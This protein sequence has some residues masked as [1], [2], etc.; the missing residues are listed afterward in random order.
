MEFREWAG[1]EEAI[2]NYTHV[3]AVTG[4]K[5]LAGRL[6][7]VN[8]LLE[9]EAQ[10]GSAVDVR[11]PLNKPDDPRLSKDFWIDAQ[12]N[13]FDVF[14][15]VYKFTNQWYVRLSAQIY[16]DLDDFEEAAKMFIILCDEVNSDK[17]ITEK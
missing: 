7:T 1:G 13:R 4:G 2:R 15:S 5:Y 12:L 16:N 3:L 9:N 6:G 17:F 14:A 10:M 11:L 8:F